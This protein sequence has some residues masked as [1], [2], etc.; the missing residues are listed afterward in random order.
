MESIRPLFFFVAHLSYYVKKLGFY[1]DSKVP[2]FTQG[3]W[4]QF[5]RDHKTAD[6]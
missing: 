3:N 2:K 4:L 5:L 6:L 1:D